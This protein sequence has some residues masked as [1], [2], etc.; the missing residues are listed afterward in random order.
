MTAILVFF[1]FV[2]F[3]FCLSRLLG[4][5]ASSADNFFVAGGQIHW[6]VNG[7]ALTG[8]YLSAASFLGIAGMISFTGFDGYLYSIGF[9]SGWVVALFVVAEPLR[10]LGKYTFA[11]AIESKFKSKAIHLAAGISTLIICMCYMVPQLVGAGVL[12]EPLLGISH[13]W[14]VILVG[15]VVV[16]FVATAGM[17]STTYVQFI[18]AGM[19]LIFSAILVVAILLRGLSTEPVAVDSRG[20]AVGHYSFI[21]LPY[22][23]GKSWEEN[24]EGTPYSFVDK[25]DTA[26]ES[27]GGARTWVLL[28]K[29][30][31]LQHRPAEPGR[32]K[33]F[34]RGRLSFVVWDPDGAVSDLL[35]DV[36]HAPPDAHS[37]GET[38][39][40]VIQELRVLER[41]GIPCARVEGWWLMGKHESGAFELREAQDVT[42]SIHGD[43]FVNGLPA[44]GENSLAPMGRIKKIGEGTGFE[45]ETG[46]IGPMSLL[47]I[48]SDSGTEIEIPRSDMIHYDDRLVNLYYHEAYAGNVFMR[49]G[50]HFPISEKSPW[51]RLD[52]ISLMVALF[53]GT[54]ALPHVLIRYYT[55]RDATAAH[56][57]TNVAITAIGVFYVMTLFLGLGAV[58]NG[59]LNPQSDNMSAPLLALSFGGTLFAII[60]AL[61]FSTVL[62]TVSGLIVA[63]SGA[64]ANDLLDMSLGLRMDEKAKV[65]AGKI[66]AVTVGLISVVLGVVLR[67]VNVSFLVGLAFA[68]AASANF[69]AI[70]MVLFWKRTTSAGIVASIL[71]GIAASLGIILA[72]PDMF[73]IYGLARADSVSPIGQ[74]AIVA[75]PLSFLTL[76][77]VSLLTPNGR[78]GAKEKSGKGKDSA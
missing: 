14:G 25:V 24:L 69:P 61:A 27:G 60:T 57:S 62:A 56:R 50:G 74:P 28:E 20:E 36:R 31:P 39:E 51:G 64:V 70:I 34:R 67:G 47:S 42:R 19:L 18:N 7:I 12:I 5:R 40:I 43:L 33:L 63:A 13:H 52:F 35:R 16:V 10:R 1:G 26:E 41:D 66:T 15:A 21:S 11:D 29:I 59:V 22:D 49:P 38:P 48:F 37:L 72:G 23:A 9:L 17:S 4:K 54:A 58:A 76:V 71:V 53:F 6:F 30:V 3:M 2:A 65:L 55:V 8:G 68:V 75:M 32:Y 77:V 45:S 73:S 44:G 78:A 46:P